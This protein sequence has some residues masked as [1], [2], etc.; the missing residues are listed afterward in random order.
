[1]KTP[2]LQRMWDTWSTR[3]LLV[4]SV[5]LRDYPAETAIEVFQFLGLAPTLAVDPARVRLHRRLRL[6]WVP[7]TALCDVPAAWAPAAGFGL[8]R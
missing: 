2:V 8:S 7:R 4:P 5:T 3:W 1:M 6:P